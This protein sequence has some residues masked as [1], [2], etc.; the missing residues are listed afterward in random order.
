[1]ISD[2]DSVPELGAEASKPSWCEHPDPDVK[3]DTFITSYS[4]EFSL[5]NG[6]ISNYF[7]QF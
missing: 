3:G 1:M 5:T 4:K 7:Y 6:M 2:G